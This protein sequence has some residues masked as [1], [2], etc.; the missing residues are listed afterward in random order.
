MALQFSRCS[1]ILSSPFPPAFSNLFLNSFNYSIFLVSDI[2]LAFNDIYGRNIFE[3]HSSMTEKVGI[4]E[5]LN[6]STMKTFPTKNTN[7]KNVMSWFPCTNYLKLLKRY[8]NLLRG[9][10]AVVRS[11]LGVMW[12]WLRLYRLWNMLKQSLSPSW[13]TWIGGRSYA[14]DNI[15]SLLMTI[16]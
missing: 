12:W 1:S 5:G 2:P 7:S 16:K 8:I 11:I 4:K 13:A 3:S 14:V 9:L 6:F 15:G 10:T